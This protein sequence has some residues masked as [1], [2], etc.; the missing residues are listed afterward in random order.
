[1]RAKGIRIIARIADYSACNKEFL[2]AFIW[3]RR[4]N[5][6]R[7]QENVHMTELECILLTIN[8]QQY[9]FEFIVRIEV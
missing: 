8:E 9:L 3:L 4:G 1:M 5:E 7:K 6:Q 2:S